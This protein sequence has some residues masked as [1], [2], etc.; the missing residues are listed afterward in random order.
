M[1]DR[2]I[3]SPIG[4]LDGLNVNIQSGV[5]IPV[6]IVPSP[7]S[8]PQQIT[9]QYN[10]VTNVAASILTTL[11]TYTVPPLFTFN[12][13]RAEIGGSN[14]A[15]YNILVNGVTI[16]TRRTWYGEGLNEIF[17]FSAVPQTGVLLNSGDILTITV[18]H[19]QPYNGDFEAT[20]IGLIAPE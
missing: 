2:F 12:I 18:E 19:F 6:Y 5:P 10:Q 15:L 1:T 13:I 11:F 20:V 3:Q 14:I 4:G 17:D 9:A 7:P 8:A 16:G